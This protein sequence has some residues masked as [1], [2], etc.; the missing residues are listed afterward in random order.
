M[1]VKGPTCILCKRDDTKVIRLGTR[2]DEAK[3]IYRCQACRLQFIDTDITDLRSYYQEE[4]RL[5]YDVVAGERITPE[6]RFRQY[7]LSMEEPANRFKEHIPNGGTVLEI[8]CSSGYFLDALQGHHEVYGN[9]WNPEDAAYVRDVGGLPCE[10]ADITE[11][12]PG[13]T[14]NAIAALQVLEHQPDP[15]A[16]LRQVKERLVGGGYL[17]LEVPNA[18]DAL[19]TVYGVEAYKAAY[20]REPH[21]TYWEMETLAY[22]LGALGFEA[23]V[24][25]RQRYGLLNHANWWMGGGRMDYRMGT[26]FLQPVPEQHPAAAVF[27]RGISKLDKEYRTLL[28]SLRAGDCITAIAR[29]REI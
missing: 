29:R 21:I 28:E 19:L 18:N 14:F 13:K 26:D 22:T 27:N 11:V 1:G 17:F 16:W 10:E 23:R 15:M 6:D 20:Y 5:R 2:E 4:Y 24:S 12:Y 3:P 8:G 25:C 9:E 7:R